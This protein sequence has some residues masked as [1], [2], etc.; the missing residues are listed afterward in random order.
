MLLLPAALASCTP[1]L[2]VHDR[3]FR[4]CHVL[5]RD[6]MDGAYRIVHAFRDA[7]TAGALAE[8]LGEAEFPLSELSIRVLDPAHPSVVQQLLVREDGL[9]QLS[10]A[11]KFRHALADEFAAGLRKNA[12]K[13]NSM[14]FDMLCSPQG[15]ATLF[16]WPGLPP[17][18]RKAIGAGNNRVS[19]LVTDTVI[20]KPTLRKELV[21]LKLDDPD[22]LVGFLVTTTSY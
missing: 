9:E 14:S 18:S 19:Y 16:G 2:V 17:P 12:G 7:P 3:W 22:L 20:R 10:T 21:V 8:V 11:W 5:Y 1:V 6:G 13:V 4:S 15:V